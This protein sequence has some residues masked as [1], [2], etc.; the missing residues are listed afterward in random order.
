MNETISGPVDGKFMGYC[1]FCGK[2]MLFAAEHTLITTTCPVCTAPIAFAKQQNAD[3]DTQGYEII[4][5]TVGESFTKNGYVVENGLLLRYEGADTAI[6]IPS[7]VVAIAPDTFKENLKIKSVVVSD[8]VKFIGNEAF[9]GCEGLRELYLSKSLISIGNAAFSHC[10]RLTHITLPE[11][12]RAGGYAIFNTCE[13]LTTL[14][15]PMNMAF[16][17]GSPYGFCKKL[18]VANIPHCVKEPGPAWFQYNDSLE[19]LT[20]G[21]NVKTLSC[22]SRVLREA[23]FYHTEGWET[24]PY[25]WGEASEAISPRELQNPKS[26]ATLLRKLSRA[27]K[28]IHRPDAPNEEYWHVL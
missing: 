5:A 24:L 12:L 15:M 8:S 6:V 2:P 25:A 22:P 16:L 18:R 17:G 19:I 27:S 9:M 7:E 26:A 21:K 4:P 1:P 28:S 11:G 23:H 10:R 20:V 3:R 13:N 14:L